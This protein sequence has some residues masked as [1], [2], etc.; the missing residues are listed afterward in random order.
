MPARLARE[1]RVGTLGVPAHHHDETAD[2]PACQRLQD[3]G[4]QGTLR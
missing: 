1:H 3:E 2:L 4:M